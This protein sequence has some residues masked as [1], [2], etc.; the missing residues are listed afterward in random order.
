M[1]SVT[2]KSDHR[3]RLAWRAGREGRGFTLL[4]LCLALLMVGVMIGVAVPFVSGA[5]RE[6]PFQDAMTELETAARTARYRAMKEGRPYSISFSGHS[7]TLGPSGMPLPD[8]EEEAG[9]GEAAGEVEVQKTTLPDGMALLVQRWGQEKFFRA[10][11]EVWLFY[12]RG[13]CEPIRIRLEMEGNYCEASFHPLSAEM[14]AIH[15]EIR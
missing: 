8:E 13:L 7:F 2:G 3:G 10:E 9:S 14:E 4:E 11:E 15:Y 12:P 5:F 6:A 1:T